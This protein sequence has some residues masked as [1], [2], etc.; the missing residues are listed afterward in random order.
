VEGLQERLDAYIAGDKSGVEN[1]EIPDG[2]AKAKRCKILKQTFCHSCRLNHNKGIF[3]A[4]Q[5]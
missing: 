1:L 2:A 4:G 5:N 3:F